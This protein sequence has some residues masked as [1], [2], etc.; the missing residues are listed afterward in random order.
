MKRVWAAVSLVLAASGVRA[1]APAELVRE[2]AQ[3]Q[4]HSAFWPN[5]H[6][7]LWAEAWA[8]RPMSADPS[9]AGQLPEPLVGDLTPEERAAWDVAVEY[10]DREVADLHPLFDQASAAMRR[11]LISAGRDLTAADLQPEHRRVLAEAA[12]VYRKYW[13]QAHDRA[14]REWINAAVA[15]VATLSPVV[16]DRLAQL[17]GTS[18]FTRPI[19][20]DVVRVSSREGAF[21]SLDPSPGHITISSSSRGN[22]GW[23]AAEVLFHESSHLLFLPVMTA[24]GTELRAQGKDT[25]GG[26]PETWNANVWHVALFYSTGEVVRQALASR[27]ITYEPYVYTMGLFE[28]A[29][30]QFKMPVEVYWKPYVDGDTSLSEAVTQVVRAI[31]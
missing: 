21:T 7:V 31:P 10:Y 20:V 9:P 11:A 27:G 22:Q 28:R 24:F 6:N 13:W 19:R 1:Q 5:L 30:P 18:W 12:P 4:L 3:L 29:W 16:P 2:Q 23:A 17:Y 15:D 14:N 25:R 26:A 8:R